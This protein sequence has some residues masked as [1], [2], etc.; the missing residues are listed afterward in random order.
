MTYEDVKGLSV[1]EIIKKKKELKASLFDAR[2]KNA[3]GQMND[4]ISIRKMRRQIA[5]L[6]MAKAINLKSGAKS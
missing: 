6:N 5:R 2:M 1:S 4:P 3:M